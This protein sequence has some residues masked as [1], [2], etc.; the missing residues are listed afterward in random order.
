MFLF[1]IWKFFCAT[2]YEIMIFSPETPAGSLH[3]ITYAKI[4][5]PGFFS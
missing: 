4:E 3:Q 1:E 5:R 2:L